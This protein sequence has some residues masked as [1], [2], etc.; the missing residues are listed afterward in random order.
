MLPTMPNDEATGLS[1]RQRAWDQ[2]WAEDTL[3]SC[4]GSFQGNYDG[5]I[6]AF[7]RPVFGQFPEK[8]SVLDLGTGN[9]PL[10]QLMLQ[11]LEADRL[12]EV[13]GVDLSTPQPRWLDELP[14][15]VKQR[16]QFHPKVRIEQLP[17]D[18]ARFDAIVSQF[19]FE[20]ADR[21][22]ATRELLRV[23]APTATIAMICHHHASRLVEVAD[24]EVRHL[25][26]LLDETE[27]FPSAVAMLP[28][29]AMSATP[30]GRERLQ[31][32]PEANVARTRFN[33]AMNE[34]AEKAHAADIPDALQ[35]MLAYFPHLMQWTIAYG[36][37]AGR[38]MLL[39]TQDNMRN[40]ALRSQELREFALD[41]SEMTELRSTLEQAGFVTKADL[42]KEGDYLMGWG[43]LARREKLS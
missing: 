4:A 36:E 20:Y 17:F 38:E 3:H 26:W 30:A 16:V 32:D 41:D 39:A 19:G 25:A 28:Y 23:A 33:L 12:G 13:H 15:A 37:Q 11:T 1:A 24:H 14:S 31:R 10:P 43:L 5:A 29:V 6:A 34:L 21:A 22:P 27:I 2:Y 7:W 40:A 18:D 8:A 9:G 42:I 35:D